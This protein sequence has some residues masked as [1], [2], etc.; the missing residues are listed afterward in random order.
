MTKSNEQ[1]P[2]DLTTDELEA[3][4]GGNGLG[5]YVV[6]PPDPSALVP[7]PPGAVGAPP[8]SGGV[9]APL[10]SGGISASTPWG[11]FY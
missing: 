11:F 5:L 7:P 8:P 6:S 1:T 3:V 2:R 4:T 10:P 9:S